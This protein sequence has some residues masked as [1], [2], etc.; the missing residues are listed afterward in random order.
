MKSD[1]ALEL[2]VNRTGTKMLEIS[3]FPVQILQCLCNMFNSRMMLFYR[4]VPE[5]CIWEYGADFIKSSSL[6]SHTLRG[7][8]HFFL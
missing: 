5:C 2:W 8:S 6:V 7:L 1:V 4:S 3:L